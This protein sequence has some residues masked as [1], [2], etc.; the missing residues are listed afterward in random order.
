M[1][2]TWGSH[3]PVGELRRNSASLTV[4]IPAAVVVQ[5]GAWTMEWRA[6]GR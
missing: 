1:P 3:W 6:G 5:Q 4:D 2:C